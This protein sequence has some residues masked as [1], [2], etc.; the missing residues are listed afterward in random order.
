MTIRHVPK[1]GECAGWKYSY[2]D[3]VLFYQMA[4]LHLQI[5]PAGREEFYLLTSRN[6]F[7][8]ER[9]CSLG[10]A[11]SFEIDRWHNEHQAHVANRFRYFPRKYIRLRKGQ[12]PSVCSRGKLIEFDPRLTGPR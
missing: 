6:Q 5:W 7:P 11:S 3:S 10:C 1:G 9:E 8:G 2:Q 4:R 12:F